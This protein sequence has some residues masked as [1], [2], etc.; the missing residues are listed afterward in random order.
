MSKETKEIDKQLEYQ[1]VSDM[2]TRARAVS[3]SM[4][5][6]LERV[7]QTSGLIATLTAG[8]AGILIK[9][10]PNDSTIV[11]HYMLPTLLIT[12][13][14]C[15]IAVFISFLGII[16]SFAEID[17]KSMKVKIVKQLSLHNTTDE[18]VEKYKSIGWNEGIENIVRGAYLSLYIANYKAKKVLWSGY[19]LLGAILTLLLGTTITVILYLFG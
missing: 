9:L 3:E 16:H 18:E 2:K 15:F 5:K 6:R 8:F 19:C 7:M 4:E 17:R 14:L 11:T 1:V 10:F 12:L 13:F